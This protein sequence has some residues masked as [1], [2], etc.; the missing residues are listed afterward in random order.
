MNILITGGAGF[1]GSHV[2]DILAAG[3]NNNI[4]IIDDLSTGKIENIPP[5][6]LFYEKNITDPSV[7][8][9]FEKEKPEILIHLAAQVSVSSSVKNPFKDME[10]NIKGTLRLLEASVKHGVKKVVF[11]STGGAIYGEHDYFPAD[12]NHVLQPLSPYGISKLCAEKYLYSY[13]KTYGLPYTVL[14]YSNVYGPRQDPFGEAGVIAIFVMKMLN[15]EQPVINGTGEQTRDFVYVKDVAKANLLALKNDLIGAVNI[16]TCMEISIN[17]TFSILKKVTGS[18]LPEKHGPALPGEQLRS[19]LSYE[20]A[21]QH[22][23]WTPATSF[24]EGLKETVN[25]FRKQ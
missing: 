16:S 12:E 2:A 14:R 17:E 21:K 13:Y 20:K 11:S 18:S 22:I 4:I 19:V 7:E 25:F 24:E 1:I 15:N 5:S 9:I 6:A 23:S 8:E 10:T 3:N